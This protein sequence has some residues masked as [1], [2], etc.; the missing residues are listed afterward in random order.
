MIKLVL[1]LFFILLAFGFSNAQQQV[2]SGQVVDSK[3]REPLKGITVVLKDDQQKVISFK[4]TDQQGYFKLL[5]NKELQNCYLEVNHLGYKRKKIDIQSPTESLLIPLEVA[6]VLL[7]DVEIKSRPRIRQQ[8]DTLS[9][10]VSSFAKSEDRSI[11]DVLKRMPGIE[12]SESGQIKY[13]GKSISNFYIDGDDLLSDKYKIGTHTIK[14]NMV[15]DVQVL[16]NHEHMKVM[17]NKRYS[18]EVALNLVI[19]DEAKMKLSGQSKVGAGLPHQ[20][21]VEANTILFNKKY[22]GLNVLQANNVGRDLTSE[23]KG[24]DSKSLLTKLGISPINNLL[25]LGTVGNPPIGQPYYLLNHT[26][27]LNANNLFHLKSKWQVV[28]N[29]Q[30]IYDKNT[31]DFSGLTQYYTPTDTFTFL[32][33]QETALKQKLAALSLKATKN[34]ENVF[35]M[36]TLQLEYEHHRSNG[37]VQQS[38]SPFDLKKRYEIAGFRNTLNYVPILKNGNLLQMDWF[39]D[40]GKKPQ[41]LSISPGVFNAFLNDSIPYTMTYQYVQVPTFSTNASIGYRL[42]KGFVNQYYS[43]NATID[44]QNLKTSMAKEVDRFYTA[45]DR[46]STTNDMHWLRSSFAFQASY[47][48]I[49]KRFSVSLKL[50]IAYQHTVYK[51]PT[52]SLQDRQGKILFTPSVLAR[53]AVSRESDLSFMYNRAHYFGNIE[54]VYLGY[55]IRNYRSIANNASGINESSSNSFDLKFK[56]G[57]TLKL[58]FYSVGL[59]Y[60]R[61]VSS[62]LLSNTIDNN[63]TQTGLVERENVVNNYGLS[64]SFDKYLF[65]LSSTVKLRA[66]ISWTDYNQLFNDMLLPYQNITYSLSPNIEAKLWKTLNLSYTASFSRVDSKE[67]GGNGTLDREIYSLSQHLGFPVTLFA[68]VHFNFSARHLYNHQAGLKDINYVFVDGLVRYRLTK[69][70]TDLDLNLTN[71]GDIKRFDT[72]QISANMET[73][74]SYPLRGRTAVIK[75]VFNF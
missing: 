14:H 34:E 17:K 16:N 36:N 61:S 68:K 37:L 9:Y 3:S 56:S 60:Q 57:K 32:E 59:N 12:V 27:G 62:T 19:K 30:V 49:R 42:P 65:A 44:D 74:N 39:V 38:N 51:D 40:Y 55:I 6:S 24:F 43:F 73:Q 53:F 67:K 11:G 69:W 13:Q 72:Y 29:L 2:F 35:V 64:T 66:T 54:N 48:L 41:Q 71:L 70:R 75:A 46:D 5:T 23:V 21:D 22:K 1:S 45:I 18:D 10:D 8:G 33:Q 15:K 31:K 52:Y 47:D 28:S 7:E 20:Y 4:M 58:L 26:V 25:S 50:P 63:V